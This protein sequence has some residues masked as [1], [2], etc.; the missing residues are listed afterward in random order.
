MAKN[1]ILT[2][3]D[4]IKF[5]KSNKVYNFSS[6]ETGKPI[7]VQSIQDFSSADVEE[8]EDGKLYCKVRV[9]H[10]LLNRNKSFISEESMTK[11]MPTPKYSPLLAMIHQLDD[12]TWDFHSPDT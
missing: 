6:Q 5:C 11:A 1:K 12:G 4:L 7:V 3:E 9:C 2:I 8:S 10:T